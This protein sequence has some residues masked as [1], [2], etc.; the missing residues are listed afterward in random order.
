MGESC[1]EPDRN[2]WKEEEMKRTV[3]GVALATLLIGLAAAAPTPQKLVFADVVEPISLDPHIGNDNTTTTAITMV[4]DGLLENLGGKFVPG[5]AESY[6]VS[7]DGAVYTFKLRDAKWSDGLPVTAQQFVDTY[8]RMLTREDAMDLAYLIYPIKNALPLKERKVDASK[9]GAK[10]LDAKTLQITLEG[11]YSFMKALFASSPMFPIRLDLAE[12]FGKDY[13]NAPDKIVSCGPYLLKDWKHGDR[14]VFEK[15]PTYWNAKAVRT[16]NVEIVYISDANTL[17][18]MYETGEIS[19]CILPADI[20]PAMERTEGFHYYNSGAVTFLCFSNKGTSPDRAK[21]I[22]N[23]N[24]IN[25]LSRAIDREDFVKALYPSNVPFTGVINPSINDE[26]GGKWSDHYDATNKYHKV[27]ANIAEAKAFMDKACKELG[28]ESADKMPAF[29]MISTEGE[30]NRTVC[31]YFQNVWKKTFGVQVDIKQLAFAQ[32]WDNFYGAPYD[33]ARSGWGPDYDDPFTYLDM[34]DSRG[35]W[36]KT[37]WVGE[38]YYKLITE[39]NKQ[40]NMKKRDDMFYQAEAILL[41]EAPIIPIMARRGAYMLNEKK[42]EGV[43]FNTFAPNI[44]FRFAK[45]K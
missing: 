27:K 22:Q 1:D 42:V 7:P 39:A 34:W 40:G 5:L 13:G 24:F 28:Y 6:T 14:M 26:M 44:D 38:S 20:I 25:A 35:G 21:I 18:N 45:A 43:Y 32:Y 29:E 37:G 23:R 8:V 4:N 11:P 30:L 19:F 10:A 41:Q 9:F 3:L 15:N 17:K 36:N 33:I 12:K 31:E 2:A 16:P